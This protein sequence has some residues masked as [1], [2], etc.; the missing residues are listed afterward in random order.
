MSWKSLKSC[1]FMVPFQSTIVM[2]HACMQS[3]LVLWR[4]WMH[5]YFTQLWFEQPKC[6]PP[7][8]G[9]MISILIQHHWWLL[10]LHLLNTLFKQVLVIYQD[11]SDPLATSSLLSAPWTPPT[12]PVLCAVL[13]CMCWLWSHALCGPKHASLFQCGSMHLTTIILILIC[14]LFLLLQCLSDVE[15]R[16]SEDHTDSIISKMPKQTTPMMPHPATPTS[17]PLYTAG[18]ATLTALRERVIGSS[19]CSNQTTHAHSKQSSSAGAH[20]VFGKGSSHSVGGSGASISHEVAANISSGNSDTSRRM[21]QP[22]VH[23]TPVATA[24]TG[25]S[26]F[27]NLCEGAP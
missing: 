18:D 4:V 10:H 16:Y 7:A 2:V 27:N 1:I 23:E 15:R 6:L 17:S 13:L 21:P 3:I 9:I 24:S 22:V 25:S 11:R 8:T 20:L 12:S 14:M 19:S 5:A 26:I